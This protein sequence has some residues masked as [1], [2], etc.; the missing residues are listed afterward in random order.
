MARDSRK[1]ASMLNVL[2]STAKVLREEGIDFLIVLNK[3]TKE[4]HNYSVNVSVPD[5]HHMLD[6]LGAIMDSWR[7]SNH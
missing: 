1:I 5:D 6:M 4:D 3:G 2:S 7:K